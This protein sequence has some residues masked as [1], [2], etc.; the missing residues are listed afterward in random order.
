LWK[1]QFR[2]QLDLRDDETLLVGCYDAAPARSGLDRSLYTDIKTYLPG[3]LLVKADRMSMAASLEGRSPFLDHEVMAWAARLP[4]RYKVRGRT[5]KYLLRKA[6]QDKLPAS[7]LEHRKQGFGIPV[8]AWLR[9]PLR[10]WSR[11][12]VF[13]QLG[14]WFEEK[15][16][17][18]LFREHDDMRVDHGKR[19]W[20]LVVLGAWIGE[21]I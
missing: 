10:E 14:D 2:D 5:G 6:F 17:L 19:L 7:I 18:Q 3:D 9:G 13:G 1:Q 15:F 21:N 12:M 8:A 16:L 4:E 20:A 11:E